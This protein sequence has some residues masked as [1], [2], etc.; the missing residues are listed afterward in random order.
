MLSESVH[1]H[2]PPAQQKK[3]KQITLTMTRSSLDNCPVCLPLQLPCL[4]FAMTSFQQPCLPFAM[5]SAQ[6]PS[7][8]THCV[9]QLLADFTLV[10]HPRRVLRI[11]LEEVPAPRAHN[12]KIAQAT[13][14]AR[15]SETPCMFG[16]HTLPDKRSPHTTGARPPTVLCQRVDI[17]CGHKREGGH[18]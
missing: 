14:R 15:V 17:S 13:P 2:P 4:P 10:R 3:I 18:S 5:T 16:Q 6:Q 9:V 1:K 11:H 7:T 12:I 8:L